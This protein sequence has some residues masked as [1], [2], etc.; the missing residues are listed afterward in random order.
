M[1]LRHSERP[2]VAV[3]GDLHPPSTIDAFPCIRCRTAAP[4][5]P[6]ATGATPCYAPSAKIVDVDDEVAA[7]I[8][9]V[10]QNEC[11]GPRLR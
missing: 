3:T 9:P 1:R 11:W 7:L 10:H 8:Y 5:S 4:V 6:P 2:F